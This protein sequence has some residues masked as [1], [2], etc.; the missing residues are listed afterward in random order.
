MDRIADPQF[1]NV[2]DYDC[3]IQIIFR[4]IEG[5]VRM[6]QDADYRRLVV[7]DHENFADTKRSR[8]TCRSEE[9][10]IYWLEDRMTIGYI[11]DIVDNIQ[12]KW[13]MLQHLRLRP[14]RTIILHYCWSTALSSFFNN[15]DWLPA[16]IVYFYRNVSLRGRLLDDS[17]KL[18]Y[19]REMVFHTVQNKN[20]YP[21]AAA[22]SRLLDFPSNYL[23]RASLWILG[24]NTN[25]DPSHQLLP[26]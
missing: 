4:D 26:W 19:R 18:H 10:Q 22:K 12:W 3:V 17:E 11:Q 8:Y 13:N 6:K 14:G 23:T 1:A 7:P 20:Y 16:L 5:F 9:V 15:D 25:S 2:A 24:L 21:C